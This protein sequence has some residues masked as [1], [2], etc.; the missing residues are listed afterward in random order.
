MNKKRNGI[1]GI[2]LISVML[3]GVTQPVAA[4]SD[5]G[6]EYYDDVDSVIGTWYPTE[7]DAVEGGSLGSY[8]LEVIFEIWYVDQ[9]ADVY[10]IRV[11]YDNW[12]PHPPEILIVKY[13]WDD[14]DPWQFVTSCAGSAQDVKI[15]ID[16]AESSVLQ[17][18]FVDYSNF[19]DFYRQTWNFGREPEL[20][21]YW[22]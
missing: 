9:T 20:W 16:D 17:I 7:N 15:T 8:D 11:D 21:M 10:K 18:Q 22:Y 5:I 19:L 14:E 6:V 12:S 1:L 2:V 3:F 4:W 13:R